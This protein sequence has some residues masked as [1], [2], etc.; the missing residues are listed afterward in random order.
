MGRGLPPVNSW[1]RH[2]Q[3]SSV[4]LF[5]PLQ[6]STEPTSC[7]ARPPAPA[8]G[9]AGAQQKQ[10]GRSPLLLSRGAACA[11]PAGASSGPPAEG[12]MGVGLGWF[13]S[14]LESECCTGATVCAP[15]AGASSGPSAG[16]GCRGNNYCATPHYK[17]GSWHTTLQ[18]LLDDLLRAHTA[19]THEGTLIHN[20]S[21]A[22]RLGHS[23]PQSVGYKPTLQHADKHEHP[24][25]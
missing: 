1:L 15:P 2:T 21:P 25:T 7:P 11:P 23:A 20:L 3:E 5:P 14:P 6:P 24:P 16:G 19:Q 22:R 10:A 12:G 9:R 13:G 17:L 4:L 8:P 18:A